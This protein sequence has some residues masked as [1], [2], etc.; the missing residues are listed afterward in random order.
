M[1]DVALSLADVGM[2][3]Y[4]VP[5]DEYGSNDARPPYM[6]T[7]RIQDLAVNIDHDLIEEEGQEPWIESSVKSMD[8][9]VTATIERRRK[10]APS[11][12]VGHTKDTGRVRVNYDPEDFVGQTTYVVTWE[13]DDPQEL[14]I[15]K[16]DVLDAVEEA[17]VDSL[18]DLVKAVD[19]EFSLPE[20]SD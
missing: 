3:F 11:L 1:S 6:M 19:R 14:L 15:I 17:L 7:L 9:T 10:G 16:Q 13:S 20:D 18:R 5:S 2:R 4:P 12:V 8:C